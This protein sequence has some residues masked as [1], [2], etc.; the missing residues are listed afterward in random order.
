MLI[1]ADMFSLASFILRAVRIRNTEK[2]LPTETL[3]TQFIHLGLFFERKKEKKK[4][5]N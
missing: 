5:E 1:F 4:K 3:A 2:A